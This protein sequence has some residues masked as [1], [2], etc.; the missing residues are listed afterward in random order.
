[1]NADIMKRADLRIISDLI[2][3][4]SRV[5]DVGCGDGA[6]L[7]HLKKQKNIDGHG[8]ELRQSRVNAAVTKGL[9]VIQGDAGEELEEYPDKAFDYVILSRTL[10]AT[11]NPARML[12]QLI[13]VG[14]MG[15]VSL[16]NFGYWR[17]RLHLLRKG[18]MPMGGSLDQPWYETE[19]I[20][21]CT[22][23][24]FIELI[25]QIGIKIEDRYGI[26]DNREQRTQ[27]SDAWFN[28]LSEEAVFVLKEK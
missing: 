26:V 18:V 25:A 20:H 22:V 23:T 17:F 5:L 4:G 14:K 3:P 12:R 19:N 9:A 15:V 21:L 13:R 1:M 16:P 10:P 2:K 24:D 6:L 7:H 8:I 28:L 27:P 11:A